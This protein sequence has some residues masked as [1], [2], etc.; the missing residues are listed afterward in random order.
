MKRKH[1]SEIAYYNSW[2][3]DATDF[4]AGNPTIKLAVEMAI[5]SPSASNR[6]PVRIILSQNSASF[7]TANTDGMYSKMSLLDAGIFMSHFFLALEHEG[8]NPKTSMEDDHPQSSQGFS[9]AGT[10]SWE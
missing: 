2:G 5:L 9:Y 8:K 6:Q 7:Y 4:L 10:V 3:S 1:I